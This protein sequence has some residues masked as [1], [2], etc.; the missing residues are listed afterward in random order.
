MFLLSNTSAHINP[1]NTF[2]NFVVCDS[3]KLAY[4]NCLDIAN[5]YKTYYFNPLFIY[6]DTGLGKTHLLQAIA[7]KVLMDDNH[8]NVL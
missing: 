2:E 7:N 5:N 8:C 3:N 6:G 1:S 4:S